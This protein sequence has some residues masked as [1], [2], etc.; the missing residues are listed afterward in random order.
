MSV[1]SYEDI[2]KFD[3]DPALFTSDLNSGLGRTLG[4][5][6]WRLEGGG[7]SLIP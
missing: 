6:D 4:V 1:D 2:L 3:E 5:P 7:S